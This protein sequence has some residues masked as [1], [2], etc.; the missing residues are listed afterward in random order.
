MTK[1]NKGK[2]TEDLVES[3]CKIM[4]LSDFTIRSPKYKKASGLQKEAA[5]FLVPFAQH[6]LAFQV[7]SKSEIKSWPEK[8]EKD[9]NRINAIIEKGIGQL[10]T[11]KRALKAGHLLE[12]RNSRG[13]NIPFDSKSRIKLI[14][15]VIVDLIGEEHFRPEERTG[16]FN[17][18]TYHQEIPV[19]VFLRADFDLIATE[20]DT[21]PDFIEFL[22]RR[23][24]LFSKQQLGPLTAE[25][26]FLAIY[27]TRP[28][29]ISDCLEGKCDLLIIE[30]GIWDRYIVT[31]RK[32]IIERTY[33]NRP[34]YLVD[35]IITTIH[36][37]I[38][39]VP[40]IK[41]PSHKKAHA[42]GTVENY[43][44]VIVELSKLTRLQRR[45]VG[46][47]L[48]EKMKK[49]DSTGH[50][51][52]LLMLDEKSALFILSSDKDR[53]QRF[54]G[55]YNLSA[56][57]YCGLGLKKIVGI[58]TEPL[59]VK[60]RSYDGIVLDDVKFENHDEFA[61]SF[62]TSFGAPEPFKITEYK[63]T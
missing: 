23:E 25:L 44:G 48:L 43:W 50:G 6:L 62:K 14:G 27:K 10:N 52:A 3:V 63:S 30:G 8:D 31:H 9:F 38:D 46:E 7:K 19:H 24:T 39:Y 15:I 54:N 34:S 35:S 56:I 18:F 57:A 53:Q 60:Y 28:A 13:I 61:E 5:D 1:P 40:N 20:I 37:S 22:D 16:V 21:L 49:A 11:I 36:S 51:H 45:S 58:A 29:L 17:G 32:N 47:K 12:M 41:Y 4:F 2:E 42:L 33:L 55:L 59:S 26:D